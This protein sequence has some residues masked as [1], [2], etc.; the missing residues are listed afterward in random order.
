[1]RI[2]EVLPDGATR[3]F[4]RDNGGVPVFQSERLA[5]LGSSNGSIPAVSYIYAGVSPIAANVRTSIPADSANSKT[6]YFLDDHLGSILALTDDNGN[7]ITNYNY[8]EFGVMTTKKEI[9][10]NPLTTQPGATG[11]LGYT[12]QY[13]DQTA[14]LLYLRNRFYNPIIGRFTQIDPIYPDNQY[15]YIPQGNPVNY[16]DVMGLKNVDQSYLRALIDAYGGVDKIP[17]QLLVSNE[18]VGAG[19]VSPLEYYL[20]SGAL[21]V[22]LTQGFYIT[23]GVIVLYGGI[24]FLQCGEAIKAYNKKVDEFHSWS[25][26][27]QIPTQTRLE[28]ILG[29]QE[30]LDMKYNCYDTGL[31]NIRM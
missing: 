23:A 17:P 31:G 19:A 3:E 29:T 26:W 12:G 8:D 15:A 4:F 9:L 25:C 24:T 13:Q 7:I 27:D 16:T 30:W 14:N 10:P 20:A 6:V 5:G 11:F 28:L 2:R 22:A 21:G 18:V 1:M